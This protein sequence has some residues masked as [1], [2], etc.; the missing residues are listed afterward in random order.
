MEEGVVWVGVVEVGGGVVEVGG[1]EEAS[2]FGDAEGLV[3][4]CGE[5]GGDGV[6]ELVGADGEGDEFVLWEGGGG[7]DDGDVVESAGEVVDVPG[8][9]A[10]GECGE[11]VGVGGGVGGV[12]GE[13]GFDLCGWGVVVW[14]LVG[15]VGG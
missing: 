6:C 15:G 11:F 5:V 9:V 14:G 3:V 12:E 2:E 4:A 8:D 7:V 1:D 10:E 13:G